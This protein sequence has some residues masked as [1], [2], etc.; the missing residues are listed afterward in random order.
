MIGWV[1]DIVRISRMVDE[2]NGIV[3]KPDESNF[4]SESGSQP[5]KSAAG[6]LL[7][8][9]WKA[10][11]SIIDSQR[12]KDAIAQGRRTFTCKFCGH[13]SDRSFSGACK[14]S[15]H[16]NHETFLSN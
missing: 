7:K 6:S 2:A 12:A 10:G 1:T 4:V 13:T 14:K 3:S 8:G 9:I 11:G 15:P 16:G 5:K